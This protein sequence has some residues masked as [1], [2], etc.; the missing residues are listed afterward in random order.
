MSEL[1]KGFLNTKDLA[2][3]YRCSNQ[4][5]FRKVSKGALPQPAIQQNGASNLWRIEDIEQFEDKSFINSN[6]VEH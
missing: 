2:K 3:R 5:I 4:T 6:P 1:S